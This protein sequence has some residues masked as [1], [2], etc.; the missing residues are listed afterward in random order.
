M[1]P[2]MYNMERL[3]KLSWNLELGSNESGR[4]NPTN[5]ENKQK[6]AALKK[7]IYVIGSVIGQQCF[8][9]FRTKKPTPESASDFFCLLEVIRFDI[10]R[11]R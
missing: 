1:G 2:V 8:L 5:P 3:R 6:H 9:K 7:G 4:Y 10:L 11:G